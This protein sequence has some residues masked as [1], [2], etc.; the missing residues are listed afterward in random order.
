MTLQMNICGPHWADLPISFKC[1]GPHVNGAD[2]SQR[3]TSRRRGKNKEQHTIITS[4]HRWSRINSALLKDGRAQLFFFNWIY[5]FFPHWWKEIKQW[6]FVE[7][8]ETKVATHTVS[9]SQLRLCL[10]CSPGFTQ[11]VGLPTFSQLNKVQ[12]FPDSWWS[13]HDWL[14]QSL[15]KSN[16][17]LIIHICRFNTN[18]T[19]PDITT[20]YLHLH[21]TYTDSAKC[22]CSSGTHKKEHI[23]PT[24]A[25][26]L[27]PC[28]F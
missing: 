19:A 2:D 24:W 7:S 1:R 15:F 17:P 22:G 28:P 18:Q 10:L 21:Y 3:T 12:H 13:L 25:S 8:L 14:I 5:V 16:L 6:P 26:P 27:A 11:Q 23:T 9:F 4:C 20:T